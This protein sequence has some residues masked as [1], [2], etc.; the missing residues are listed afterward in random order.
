[1]NQKKERAT[2]L[3]MLAILTQHFDK[4]LRANEIIK[5]LNKYNLNTNTRTIAEFSKQLRS[6]GYYVVSDKAGC[7]GYCITEDREK[8]VHFERMQNS[9]IESLKKEQK[10]T[11][12]IIN[13]Y[14]KEFPSLPCER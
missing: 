3:D 11:W 2:C 10:V 1:M 4:W 6:L 14:D 9:H 13:K 12:D 5:E 7:Y 8:I